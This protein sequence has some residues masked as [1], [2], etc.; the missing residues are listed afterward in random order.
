MSDYRRSR[1]RGGTFFFTVVTYQRKPLLL[2]AP[3]RHALRL[4]INE[5]RKRLPFD[6]NAWVLLPEH[7]HCLWTLPDADDNYSWRWS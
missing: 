7:L 5:T 3:V 1:A 2:D 6:I 4:A